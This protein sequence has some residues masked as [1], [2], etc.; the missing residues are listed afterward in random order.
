MQ[1][2]HRAARIPPTPGE[3]REPR[4]FVAIDGAAAGW[5][6]LHVFNLLLASRFRGNVAARRHY[7]PEAPRQNDINGQ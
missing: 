7:G 2:R 5:V 4:Y 1:C 6:V 3:A